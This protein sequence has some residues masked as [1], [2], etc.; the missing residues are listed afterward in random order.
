[1]GVNLGSILTRDG[2]VWVFSGYFRVGG[3]GLLGIPF[4]AGALRG[5]LVGG[6]GNNS[7]ENREGDVWVDWYD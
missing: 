4:G 5:R 3:S 2:C 1:M 7:V 6:G